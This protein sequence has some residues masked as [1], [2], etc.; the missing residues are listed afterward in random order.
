MMCGDP[1]NFPNVFFSSFS[2]ESW[3]QRNILNVCGWHEH[4]KKCQAEL[5]PLARTQPAVIMDPNFPV[6]QQGI[7]Y[8]MFIVCC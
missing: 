3:D 5:F 6:L 1:R 2:Y 7:Q 4:Y 8:A